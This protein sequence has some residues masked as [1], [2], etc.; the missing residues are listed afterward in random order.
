MIP[1]V[2][3]K[4]CLHNWFLKTLALVFGVA[5]WWYA[6][7][8][9]YETVIR[10]VPIE[11]KIVD[12]MTVKSID[13]SEIKV[14]LKY[15]RQQMTSVE[16]RE[17]ELKIIHDQS[18]V[19]TLGTVF[20]DL[21]DRDLQRSSDFREVEFD[22]VRIS[23]ELDRLGEKVLPVKVDYRGSVRRGYRVVEARA[24]P[25]EVKVAGPA[26]ILEG[27]SEITTEPINLKG[28]QTTFT[29]PAV[30]RPLSAF[31]RESLP[32][33]TVTVVIGRELKERVF[34]KVRVD[35]LRNVIRFD[36]LRLEPREIDL[37]LKG[38]ESIMDN[39][40]VSALRVYVDIIGLEP[41]TWELPLHTAFPPEVQ[42]E[43]AQP[44]QVKVTLDRSPVSPRQP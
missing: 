41:G 33:V 17:T 22:P 14:T 10:T 11:L 24:N 29:D 12:G 1:D 28:Q 6:S 35:I 5:A 23:A 36:Q 30:L 25:S 20:F 32:E 42:L 7:D 19:D 39:L 9:V 34:E 8:Y 43:R 21:E 15:P 2:I 44:S 38:P 26:G 31:A 27:M 4:W 18:G 16:A 40:T 37:Y 3:K 13:P